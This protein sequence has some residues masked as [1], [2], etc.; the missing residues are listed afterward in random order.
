MSGL[1]LQAGSGRNSAT[2]K[3]PFRGHGYPHSRKARQSYWIKTKTTL[4][5]TLFVNLWDSP[6][7]L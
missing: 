4:I 2:R 5:S 3:V 6:A 7:K 1:V